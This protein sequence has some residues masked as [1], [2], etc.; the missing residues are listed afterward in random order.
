MNQTGNPQGFPGITDPNLCAG[1]GFL[2]N[3][4][5]QPGL[6]PFDL[7]RGGALFNFSGSAR[8][9]EFAFYAQD[10]ITY[11]GF[12]LW[13]GLRI[14]RYVGLS[15]ATGVQ[16]RMGVSYLVKQ[17]G[18]VLRLAYSRTLETPYNENLV[19]SSATG[20]GGLATNIFGAFG[21]Q[22]LKSGL[23]N[24]YNAGLQQ[25]LGRFFVFD[26]DY[27]WKF[28]D[29]AFDFDT[30]FNTPITFPI[31]W[32]QSKIDG[33]SLRLGT[34]SIHGVQAEIIAGHTRARFFGPEVGGLIFNSPLDT[35][36]F[37]I[38]HDQAFQQTT[39][40]RYQRPHNGPWFS[41]T[42][43]YDG[44]EVAGAVTDLSDALNLTAAEQAAIG[45]F[46]GGQ[47]ATITNPITSCS[48]SNYGATRL[49]IPA[50]GTFNPDLNPP[51]VA[52]RNLFDLGI[53]TDNLFR[54]GNDKT[55][56]SLR[57]SVLNLTNT[58]AL[59]NFLSTFS[60]THFVSPRTYQA[61]V[62]FL[63]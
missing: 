5:L 21:S 44:G 53:G 62:K 34:T 29:N 11:R 20:S 17:T 19:L 13:P 30:L 57:F 59:Y 23:R 14:D 56:T 49:I 58:V 25:S 51:R 7:T 24:Q 3:P 60:G 16:P 40:I 6:V 10:E 15:K 33:F 55:R 26:G 35:G 50:A 8:I 63:F 22:P 31:S 27:F 39:N 48:G 36:V 4:D 9:N 1:A 28:T 45:F 42:W 52:S 2:P 41:F 43:R 12:T 18:T 46:C 61:E 47:V 37:R 54:G 38:D 32:R